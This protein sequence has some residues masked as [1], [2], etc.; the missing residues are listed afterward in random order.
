M[1]LASLTMIVTLYPLLAALPPRRREAA[2]KI[3]PISLSEVPRAF[4]QTILEI[5]CESARWLLGSFK[6]SGHSSQVGLGDPQTLIS[7]TPSLTVKRAHPN[8]RSLMNI[9][10]LYCEISHLHRC[11]SQKA[12][13]W[14]TTLAR[15]GARPRRRPSQ[16]ACSLTNTRLDCHAHQGFVWRGSSSEL[17]ASAVFADIIT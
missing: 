10:C 9:G 12:L 11:H 1:R 14:S 17:L 16:S 8:T 13:S 4:S 5:R 7:N 6:N 2:K 15:H 3:S